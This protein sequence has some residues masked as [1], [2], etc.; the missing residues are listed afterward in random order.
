L[1]KTFA[2]SLV[3]LIAGSAFAKDPVD[4][5]NPKQDI[6]EARPTQI[7]KPGCCSW[8]KGVCGCAGTRVQ[9]CDGTTSPSCRCEKDDRVVP[10]RSLVQSVR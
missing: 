5:E 4:S 2:A 10:G 3:F 6:C 8:H 9:C 1:I 7:A